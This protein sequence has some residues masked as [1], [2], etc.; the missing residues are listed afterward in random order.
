VLFGLGI[1]ATFSGPL[2]YSI[3]PAHLAVDELVAGNGLVEA[4]TWC[5]SATRLFERC[6]EPA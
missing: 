1:Q 2:K 3:L 6:P 4:G 5:R